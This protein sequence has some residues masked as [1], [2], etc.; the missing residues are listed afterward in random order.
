[1][2]ESLKHK[3]LKGTLWSSV[4]RFSV[5][6]VA[7]VVM[8]VMARI[9]TPEDYGLVG[10]II[11]FIA[12]SQSLVDSGFSQALIRK[13][14][15]S[16]I[17]NS[18]VFYFNIAVGIILYLILFFCAPLIARFYD[19]PILVP[20]TRV[21]SL[22]VLLNSLVVVQRALLTVKIDFKTQA[23]ASLTA[24]VVS[25]I[26]GIYMAYTGW[27]VWAIAGQQI[28]NLAVNTGLLWVLSHWRPTLSYSWSSFRELFGFGSK[29]AI[30]GIIDTIYQNVYLIVIGKVFRTADLGYY[31]RAHQFAQ[32]PSSNFTGI[33]QRV[34]FPVLCT[35]QNDDTRLRSVYRRFLR[36][37]AF[38]VFP[39]MVGL[40]AVAHP[41]V[42]VLLKEQWAFAATL[43]SIICFSMMWYPV[44]AINLN[45]LQ[46]KGRTDLVLKL[47]IW[48]KCIGVAILCITVPMGLIAMCVGSIFSSLI[49]LGINTYYTG[50]IIQVGFLKQMRDLMPTLFYSLSMGAVVYAT[51]NI[52]PGERLQLIAGI[53]A[54]IAYFAIV[55]RLTKSQD[56]RELLAFI[57]E[58]K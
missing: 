27:G 32:F 36:L 5:Q 34:T 49:G 10:D 47:E 25:G 4:E 38:I 20:L 37:S 8:I 24:A 52:I 31:T 41:M 48:K 30:S 54:G 17:D 43:L 7:F 51:A 21:I 2:P 11:I 15:R 19:E 35:I 29:L 57:K 14:D 12:I 18:T 39:L 50:K 22:S 9:L 55:T 56:L 44:H 40:A 58:R 3:T 6:G 45:L 46:V 23:K 1:M 13:Q 26:V 53:A 28:V 16:E 33:I 42:I